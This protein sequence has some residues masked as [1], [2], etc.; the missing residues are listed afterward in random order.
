M[1]VKEAISVLKDAKTI[2]LGYCSDSI[3]FNKDNPISMDA[4]GSYVVESIKGFEDDYYEI[5]IAMRPVKV[6]E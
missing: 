2:V 6:G 4:F 3:P 1:T 5:N